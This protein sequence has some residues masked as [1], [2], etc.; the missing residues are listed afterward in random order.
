MIDLYFHE[1][2]LEFQRSLF[3]D[4]WSYNQRCGNSVP[5]PVFKQ[6]CMDNNVKFDQFP[7]VR[8]Q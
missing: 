6:F 5:Y 4:Q 7:L 8:M 1:N 3:W 2:Q